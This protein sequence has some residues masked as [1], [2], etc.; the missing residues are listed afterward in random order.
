MA[1]SQTGSIQAR[2]WRPLRVMLVVT[3]LLIT[4]QIALGEIVGA[5]ATYPS[6]AVPITSLGG[7]ISA[8]LTAAGP[9]VLVHVANALLILVAGI[10]SFAL[11]LR[12]HKRSVTISA[13]LSLVS[14]VVAVLGGYIF[15][16]SDFANGGGILL[17]V[18]GALAAYALL[19]I[20][21]Y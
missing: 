18:N 11:A 17:M 19:F 2:S 4:L 6:T 10:G 7:L 16:V 21:L 8:L 9:I 12:Y 15:A 5:V 3:L 20:T 13:V 14:I 1:G